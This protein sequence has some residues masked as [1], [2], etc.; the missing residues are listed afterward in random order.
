MLTTADL[1]ARLEQMLA[2]EMPVAQQL[3][4][5]IADVSRNGVVL[6]AAFERNR[7]H[8]GT[9]FAGSVNA[10]AT[11]AGWATVWLVLQEAGLEANAVLQDSEIRYLE[12]IMSDF[13]ADCPFP[14]RDERAALLD[15]VTRHRRGRVPVQV[16]VE[17]GDATV[18]RFY[19]RYVAL[20]PDDRRMAP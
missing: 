20:L 10:L 3:G 16:D 7:N 5:S 19:G 4:F 1:R 12:P 18:A 6:R 17:A 9:A 13:T 8:Q 11:L 14:T 15:A 2:R